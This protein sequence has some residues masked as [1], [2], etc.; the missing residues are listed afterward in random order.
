MACWIN[1]ITFSSIC[2]K[3][4]LTAKS[5]KKLPN[6]SS[7]WTSLKGWGW[8]WI[9]L[10]V[11]TLYIWLNDLLTR[12]DFPQAL[13]KWH[14]RFQKYTDIICIRFHKHLVSLGS[15]IIGILVNNCRMQCWFGWII[16]RNLLSI[17]YKQLA[18]QFIVWFF[19]F[20]IFRCRGKCKELFSFLAL[21]TECVG[22][23]GIIDRNDILIWACQV[24][25]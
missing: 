24:V 8:F 7:L 12:K 14:G 3:N 20:C 10:L 25:L 15:H 9:S 22:R 16:A 4:T 18:L 13:Q 2:G 19:E 11:H 1:C 6:P 17:W 21:S 23:L 5:S